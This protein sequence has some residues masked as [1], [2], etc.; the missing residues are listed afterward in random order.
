MRCG[1]IEAVRDRER[2]ESMGVKDKYLRQDQ[3]SEE[4]VNQPVFNKGKE[5]RNKK[6]RD[7]PTLRRHATQ[8]Y[9]TLA[10]AI[11]YVPVDISGS[12]FDMYMKVH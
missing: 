2:V 5:K 6:E 7:R 4:T 1:R 9:Q 3:D 11:V 12:F 10:E 8:A